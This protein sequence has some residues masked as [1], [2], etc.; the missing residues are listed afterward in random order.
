MR[1]TRTATKKTDKMKTITAK[2]RQT[3]KQT[4]Q[5]LI[6]WNCL[7]SIEAGEELIKELVSNGFNLFNT[8]CY[9]NKTIFIY[10]EE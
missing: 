10:V 1:D 5:I 4:V 7:K 3:Q 6:D 2:N 8:T 9:L